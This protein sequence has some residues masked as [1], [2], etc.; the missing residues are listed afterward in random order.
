MA[1]AKQDWSIGAT[2]KVGFTPLVVADKIPT[3]GDF[4]PDA[5]LLVNHAG[6]QL[7]RFVPHCGLEKITPAE[8]RELRDGRDE[9][10][11][12]ATMAVIQKARDDAR[13]A[14]EVLSALA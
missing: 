3:P 2:V 9:D 4:A 13:R 14:S 8:A 1:K 10:A 5:F 12:R 7:Y 6:T 11:S